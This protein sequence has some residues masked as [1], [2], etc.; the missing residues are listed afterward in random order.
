[1]ILCR[2]R[3]VSC[4]QP[5]LS[6]HPTVGRE[7]VCVGLADLSLGVGYFSEVTSRD[8]FTRNLCHT[9]GAKPEATMNFIVHPTARLEIKF[10]R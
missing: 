1:M 4:V 9:C 8:L 2:Y 7:L 10:A 6:L 5:H 3:K